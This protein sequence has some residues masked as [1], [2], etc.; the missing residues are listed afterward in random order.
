MPRDSKK[1]ATSGGSR[2]KNQLRFIANNTPDTM[3]MRDSRVF[4][5]GDEEGKP[6]PKFRYSVPKTSNRPREDHIPTS[7]SVQ[8]HAQ[9][10]YN[11]RSEFTTSSMV[12]PPGWHQQARA[13]S[14]STPSNVYSAPYPQGYGMPSQTHGNHGPEYP[15]PQQRFH[16][17]APAHY[18]QPDPR[19]LAQQTQDQ[20]LLHYEQQQAQHQH[21]GYGGVYSHAST[22][23]SADSQYYP[24]PLGGSGGPAYSN[25]SPNARYPSSGGSSARYPRHTGGS[26]GPYM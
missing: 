23:P 24:S 14:M 17:H 8:S 1:P 26:G 16:S 12:P 10:S 9:S 11:S 15:Y 5:T 22:F 20:G 13:H 25:T 4:K 18:Q 3:A 6:N 7:H 19:Y 2:S 21:Q